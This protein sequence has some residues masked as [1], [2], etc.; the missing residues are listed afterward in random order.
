MYV[1]RFA[2]SPSGPLHLGSLAAALAS[3]IDAKAHN[4]LWLLRIE[5]LDTPR[6]NPLF[7][8]LIIDTL[9][10]HG[11]ESDKPVVFQSERLAHYQIA[12]EAILSAKKAYYCECSRKQIKEQGGIYLNTCRTKHLHSGA[13]R[14]I[15]TQP[16]TKLNDRFKGPV[17]IDD[18]HALEDFILLRKDNIH[19]YNLAVVVD[20]IEQGITHIVRGDDLL[21][22][23]SAHLSLYR[24]FNSSPPVYAHIPVLKDAKGNKL[25]KQNHAPAISSF[26]ATENL[27]KAFNALNIPMPTH[28]KAK[29]HDVPPEL[30]LKHAIQ[31][32]RLKHMLVDNQNIK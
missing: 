19:A 2:P 27:L 6:C 29:Q 24:H 5:D 17:L 9:R 28:I 31:A 4:G 26:F 18:G 21:C 20:D 23:T 14:F 1:G 25:S 8:Q 12:L 7:S 13:V 11:M 3:Y 22:T 32:W 16:I 30:L 15:N 10:A